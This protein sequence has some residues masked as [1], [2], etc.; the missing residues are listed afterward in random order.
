MSV[1]KVPSEYRGG[2]R[3]GKVRGRTGTGFSRSGGG[4][5]GPPPRDG[6]WACES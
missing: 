2:G 1:R 5:G 4:R 3:G 6:D